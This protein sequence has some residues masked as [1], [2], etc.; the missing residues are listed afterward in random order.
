MLK[1]QNIQN[2]LF[3]V[4]FLNIIPCHTQLKILRLTRNNQQDAALY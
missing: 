2:Y 1:G 3:R 4:A